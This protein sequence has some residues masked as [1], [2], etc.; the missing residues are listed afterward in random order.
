MS[1]RIFAPCWNTGLCVIP[2]PNF[3]FM[4]WTFKRSLSKQAALLNMSTGLRTHTETA[5]SHP[6]ITVYSSAVFT[7]SLRTQ[8]HA[9]CS[10]TCKGP[11]LPV[12]LKKKKLWHRRQ[13]HTHN[14]IELQLR[15]AWKVQQFSLCLG[16]RLILHINLIL[17][18]KKDRSVPK[19]QPI[20]CIYLSFV[21][22]ADTVKTKYRIWSPHSH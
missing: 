19:Q 7:L 1:F 2:P 12:H 8:R 10:S 18:I 22:E 20:R 17:Q 11:T 5:A 14:M 9:G 4:L 6:V 3:L 13:T 21:N 15:K 16:Y